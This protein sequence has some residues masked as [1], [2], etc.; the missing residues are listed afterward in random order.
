MNPGAAREV[1]EQAH[2]NPL[3]RISSS[4]ETAE[5]PS[6]GDDEMD[7]TEV[8]V[9]RASVGAEGTSVAPAASE[10]REALEITAQVALRAASSMTDASTPATTTTTMTAATVISEA[11]TKTP[12]TSTVDAT[13]PS[14]PGPTHHGDPADPEGPPRVPGMS[15]D[16]ADALVS[17][18]D[19]SPPAGST[20]ARAGDQDA[21][22][23][24]DTTPDIAAR[25]K[26][27]APAPAQTQTPGQAPVPLTT[28]TTT[29]SSAPASARLPS[30]NERPHLPPL[31]QLTQL[32]AAAETLDAQKNG[33]RAQQ[34]PPAPM[35]N[36]SGGGGGGGG[37]GGGSNNSNGNGP[38][39]AFPASAVEMATRGR[40]PGRPPVAQPA[41]N[42]PYNLP[43]S[44]PPPTS[45]FGESGAHHEQL[46]RPRELSMSPPGVAQH[47]GSHP[48]FYNLRTAHASENGPPYGPAGPSE[49]APPAPPM[50]DN[51]LYDPQLTGHG[52]HHPMDLPNHPG[53]HAMALPP[54]RQ[55]NGHAG[56]VY[57]CTHPGCTA[58]PFNTQYLL[59]SHANVHSQ[60]RPHYCPVPNCSRAIGGKGFKRK[61]E[62]IRHG[63][64]HRSP[65]YVCPFCND[66]EHRYPRPDNLQRHVRV[67]HVDKD[68][69]DPALRDVL[70]Q[71]VEG[72]NRGRRR[73][74][75][76]H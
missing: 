40:R 64:V 46:P 43:Q 6:E 23:D 21:N 18:K 38:S 51:H 56:A 10:G 57:Q 58:P 2:A 16:A 68:K 70:A 27:S 59:N 62:M 7:G 37:S 32:A 66:R 8:E 29:S 30:D 47:Q 9:T 12:N 17:L 69:D 39:Q 60:D 49:G 11:A 14:G 41:S 35:S 71:R 74:T 76:T 31:S 25:E 44:S 3:S 34:A 24:P 72:G 42:G 48:Y 67:H 20:S 22:H 15:T 63:L 54:P 4:P 73:R 55:M 36:G 5:E 75:T 45:N 28:N 26:P 61:N 53:H 52:P 33:I 13:S 65:G 50:I 19:R 1:I